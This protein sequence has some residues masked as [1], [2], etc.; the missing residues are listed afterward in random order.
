MTTT[1]TLGMGS[2]QSFALKCRNFP[3]SPCS[4][5]TFCLT[6]SI[7]ISCY[8]NKDLF[9]SLIHNK[10]SLRPSG[11]CA[12]RPSSVPT[13]GTMRREELMAEL[14]DE[15]N[16][17]GRH[18]ECTSAHSMLVFVHSD[19]GE[20]A[21]RNTIRNTW[22]NRKLPKI[23]AV[24]V[25]F[26]LGQAG[27]QLSSQQLQWEQDINNDLIQGQ[28]QEDEMSDDLKSIVWMQWSITRCPA[29]TW[30]LKVN[31]DSFV[32]LLDLQETLALDH[33]LEGDLTIACHL[34]DNFTCVGDVFLVSRSTV[35]TL[36]NNFKDL[37]DLSWQPSFLTRSLA[38]SSGVSLTNVSNLALCQ[39]ECFV[40]N[41][42]AQSGSDQLGNTR[43]SNNFAN[44]SSSLL[45]HFHSPIWSRVQHF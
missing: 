28:P 32:D 1:T 5:A 9:S 33:Q 23:S 2:E 30:L 34:N 44:Y 20:V 6:L 38:P 3:W 39:E 17:L 19:P 25:F 10:N 40:E 4:T 29:V 36:M 41:L 31:S 11:P 26:V 24:K 35:V 16:P 12:P 8:A 22:A 15:G 7:Y 37:P 42:T 45:C 13:R 18:L 43:R 27:N 14:L 21:L